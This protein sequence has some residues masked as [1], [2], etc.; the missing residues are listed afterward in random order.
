MSEAN[1]IE[2]LPPGGDIVPLSAAT[3]FEDLKG[4][5]AELSDHYSEL[6]TNGPEDKAALKTVKDARLVHRNIRLAIEK[7]HK[8]G[9]AE[10][11]KEC[12]LWDDTKRQLVALVKPQEDRLKAEED[13]VSAELARRERVQEERHQA[14][15]AARLDRLNEIGAELNQGVVGAMDDEQFEAYFAGE[16]AKHQERKEQAE[17]EAREAAA[18][19]KVEAERVAAEQEQVRKDREELAA[20]KAEQ[21]K[22]QAVIDAE[23]ERVQKEQE[24]K[25][26]EQQ[27]IED[28]N[29]REAQRIEDEKHK[30]QVRL[31]NEAAAAERKRLADEARAEREAETLKA[32]CIRDG[33]A[34]DR[35]LAML[36]AEESTRI[37]VEALGRLAIH[38]ADGKDAFGGEK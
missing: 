36:A 30:E 24:A 35:L 14:T 28:A 29:R 31:S 27:A 23:N 10:A 5:I 8:S 21:A 12:Q 34:I 7:R 9:K 2:V 20:L 6:V 3:A 19:A 37:G 15:I 13:K 18:K 17:L 32:R 16:L 22:K 11:L 38:L 1:Q 26:A 33:E 4:E 25:R